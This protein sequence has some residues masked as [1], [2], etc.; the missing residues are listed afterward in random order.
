MIAVC[1]QDGDCLGV[2]GPTTDFSSFTFLLHILSEILI[3]FHPAE[4][5]WILG[6][7]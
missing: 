3:L 1:V 5:T 6:C 7:T 4:P 2:S